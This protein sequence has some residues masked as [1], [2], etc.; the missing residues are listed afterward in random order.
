M[1]PFSRSKSVPTIISRP[2]SQPPASASVPEPSSRSESSSRSERPPGSLSSVDPT[3]RPSLTLTSIRAQWTL[4]LTQHNDFQLLAALSTFKRL[5]RSIRIPTDESPSS[6]KDDF[7]LPTP[8]PYQILLPR[9]IALLYINI[10]LIHAFLGSYYLA[11][12]AFEEALMLDQTSAVAWFGLGIARFYSKKLSASKKAFKKCERCF[13]A[14]NVDG[15]TDQKEELVYDVWPGRSEATTQTWTDAEDHDSEGS[16]SGLDAFKGIMSSRLPNNQWRLE[17]L[18]AEWNYRVA[19]WEQDW[20]KHGVQR[21]GNWTLTGIPA[22]VIFDLDV[23]ASG[24]S[25]TEPWQAGNDIGLKE[26]RTSD[27]TDRTCADIS[28]NSTTDNPSRHKWSGLQKRFL[29]REFS[30]R[31]TKRNRVWR[32][33][34]NSQ[35]RPSPTPSNPQRQAA[36]SD[37]RALPT[38]TQ[39][40][41]PCSPGVGDGPL[42]LSSPSNPRVVQ[43]SYDADSDD[44]IHSASDSPAHFANKMSSLFPTRH[45]SLTGLPTKPLRHPRGVSL[46]INTG[47]QALD[48]IKEELPGSGS[49]QTILTNNPM[50]LKGPISQPYPRSPDSADIS[51]L[52]TSRG[53]YNGPLLLD[54]AEI[55]PLDTSHG[56]Y[57]GILNSQSFEADFRVIPNTKRPKPISRP[58]TRS[59]SIQ[60]ESGQTSFHTDSISPLESG[61]RSAFFSRLDAVEGERSRG[62]SRATNRSVNALDEEQEVKD[63]E[64]GP[65]RPPDR[66]SSDDEKNGKGGAEKEDKGDAEKGNKGDAEKNDE[67]ETMKEDGHAEQER[68]EEEEEGAHDMVENELESS[69]EENEEEAETD[70]T[71]TVKPATPRTSQQEPVPWDPHLDLMDCLRLYTGYWGPDPPREEMQSWDTSMAALR[72]ELAEIKEMDSI[73]VSRHDVEESEWKEEEGEEGEESEADVTFTITPATPSSNTSWQS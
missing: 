34:A 7:S 43:S 5:L 2:L 64:R 48:E 28:L 44:E 9:D 20:L 53:I 8:M 42:P 37:D 63:E 52:D 30:T 29:K 38:S 27:V 13:L 41:F 55:S 15:D 70:L 3:N 66:S 25:S 31:T 49:E 35:S 36:N 19:M 47:I 17:R 40:A 46:S 68:E 62:G 39:A 45:S 22:G 51:P 71:F 14:Q 33:I 11:G 56:L 69:K 21:P 72:R 73:G 54:S 32:W 18:R 67:G 61:M 60:A 58:G 57:K 65:S 24:I 16:E 12:Q 50:R 4:A 23:D 26:A 1:S 10:G 59:S 6:T